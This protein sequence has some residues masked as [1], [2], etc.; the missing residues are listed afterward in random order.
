MLN[1]L[2]QIA[3]ENPDYDTITFSPGI[4]AAF[5]GAVR[6]KHGT[7]TR[8]EVRQALPFKEMRI[9]H[10]LMAYNDRVILSKRGK[11][12]TTC[13]LLPEFRA[14]VSTENGD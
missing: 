7:C 13:V 2:T 12:E 3:K 8:N 14:K 1:S 6:E 11:K 10:K 9:E 4:W 5:Q